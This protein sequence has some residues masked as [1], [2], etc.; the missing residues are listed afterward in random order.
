[1]TN[2]A[3]REKNLRSERGAVLYMVALMMVVFGSARAST[4]GSLSSF[5]DIPETE[6]RRSRSRSRTSWGATSI[7]HMPLKWMGGS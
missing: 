1:M 6:R 7:S 3:D 2:R 5:S 4:L